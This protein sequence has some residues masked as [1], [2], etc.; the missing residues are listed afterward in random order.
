MKWIKKLQKFYFLST[1]FKGQYLSWHV[2]D[3]VADKLK[4]PNFDLFYWDVE[5]SKNDSHSDP[6]FF[7]RQYYVETT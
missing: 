5:G 4:I 7:T 1:E 6:S 2:Q 3:G